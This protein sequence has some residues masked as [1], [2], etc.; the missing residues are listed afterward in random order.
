MQDAVK[1]YWQTRLNH[2]KK[3]LEGNNFE[4]FLADT[5]TQAREVVMHTILPATA[6]RS[7]SWGGSTT[8]EQIGLPAALGQHQE[9]EVLDPFGNGDLAFD[10]MMDRCRR[11][12]GVDLFFASANAV[13]EAGQLVNLDAWGNRVAALTFG[14]KF[15]VVLVGRN[16][17]VGDLDQAME[18]VKEFAAPVNAIT[19]ELKTPCAKTSFCSECKSPDRICN[20]WTITEK[21]FPK[22]RTK[23]ILINEELGY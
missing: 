10:D 11:A 13:T 22:G 17:I 1:H 9:L 5:G 18:R 21:S 3:V 4:V 14:P 23:I 7:V 12:L 6:A 15:V 20:T 19:M 16:K 8:F 2:L